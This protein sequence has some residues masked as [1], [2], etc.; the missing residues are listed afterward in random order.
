VRSERAPNS[1]HASCFLPAMTDS[2]RFHRAHARLSVGHLCDSAFD[3]LLPPLASSKSLN[4]WTPLPVARRAAYLFAERGARR[5][6]DVGA[7]PGKFCIGAAFARPEL[8]VCGVDQDRNLIETARE[9][10]ERLKLQNLEFIA[11]DALSVDWARFDG[12]YFFNPFAEN[13]LYRAVGTENVSGSRDN[14]LLRIAERLSSLRT[15]STLVTYH[16]LGGPIPSSFDLM[17]EEHAGTDL[18]RLWV[19]NRARDADWYYLDTY[20]AVYRAPKDRV[21]Q[22]LR[23]RPGSEPDPRSAAA[24][25]DSARSAPA[26][27]AGS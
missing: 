2:D 19:K 16:G 21:E 26:P 6:L 12:F 23:V 14:E 27:D 25:T 8:E 13:D 18:L 22:E 15:G 11:G 24:D 5:I 4:Y 20:S 17:H 3:Y 10:A 7:G 9:L 1:W